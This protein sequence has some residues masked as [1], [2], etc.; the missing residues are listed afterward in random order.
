MTD[1]LPLVATTDLLEELMGRFKNAVFAGVPRYAFE[2]G[3]IK[4][5]YNIEVSYTDDDTPKDLMLS[6]S[7]IVTTIHENV[8]EDAEDAELLEELQ[9]DPE[10]V[11]EEDN[12]SG[13]SE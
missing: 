3:T 4:D 12:T 11:E 9:S 7:A 10:E 13:E 2:G 1:N 5:V 8:V 6:V